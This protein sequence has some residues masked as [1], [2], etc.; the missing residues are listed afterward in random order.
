MAPLVTGAA[1]AALWLCATLLLLPRGA[2][3]LLA[4]WPV[5]AHLV[6][7]CT[8]LAVLV[9]VWLLLACVLLER[10]IMVH[11]VMARSAWLAGTGAGTGAVDGARATTLPPRHGA[12]CNI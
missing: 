8:M 1:F 6:L 11:T 4:R 5:S 9:A 10:A 7:A 2:L 12:D 3:T